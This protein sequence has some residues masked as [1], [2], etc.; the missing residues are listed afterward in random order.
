M[1]EE[2]GD[3]FGT[4]TQRVLAAPGGQTESLERAPNLEEHKSKRYDG[5]TGIADD[6]DTDAVVLDGQTRAK[7]REFARRLNALEERRVRWERHLDIEVQQRVVADEEV[8]IGFFK[9]TTDVDETFQASMQAE[10]DRFEDMINY[11]SKDRQDAWW[12]SFRYFVDVTVP[13]VVDKQSGE[14]TRH[15]H[16]SKETFEIDNTKLLKREDKI[17]A[18]YHH[19]VKDVDQAFKQ[20]EKTRWFSQMTMAESIDDADRRCDRMDERVHTE[21]TA[22][23]VTLKDAVQGEQEERSRRDAEILDNLE[24]STARLQAAILKNF[25]AGAEVGVA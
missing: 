6:M 5:I 14:V 10:K 7:N 12:D 13:D 3:A 15:L 11:M 8:R 16:K 1:D 24:K 22:R 25:G 2:R 19:H 9:A 18:R 4:S 20:E 23:L 21:S 17:W